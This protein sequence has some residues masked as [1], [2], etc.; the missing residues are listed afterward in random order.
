MRVATWNVNNVRKRLPQLLDWLSGTQPDVVALQELKTETAAFPRA[1]IEAAGYGCL[2]A[3]QTHLE[4]RGASVARLRAYRD[5]AYA[6]R[7][8]RRQA[9]PFHRGGHQRRRRRLPVPAQRQPLA[10]AQVR[11]QAGVVRAAHRRTR[12]LSWPAATRS[13][14]P[15]TSTSSRRT[16]STS[17]RPPAGAT[18][19]CCSLEARE[20]YAR[21]LA[22][23][24]TDA[25]RAN[26]PAERV[27]T[28]WDYLRNRWP[29]DAG[30]RIDH[31]LLSP[32]LKLVDA[33]VDREMRGNDEP[34]DHAP[35]WAEVALA[36][37]APRPAPRSCRGAGRAA[38]VPAGEV[39][40]QARLRDH[41]RAVR[42]RRAERHA[43]ARRRR[44]ARRALS[45]VIQKHWASRVCTTTS[46]WSSMA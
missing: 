25:L 27:Y 11:L 17:T 28:F 38:A 14:W 8:P 23:G 45:F 16:T 24:W 12:R 15:A 35:A 34:S 1:E 26:F 18:T 7:R 44:R 29:R 32:A 2:V 3:G 9:G 19:R 37:P 31:L 30:L 46:A 41:G 6:A 43:A 20:A 42:W 40:R 4:R 39:Q 5:P 22:Q 21:L 10:R 36:K 13:S 33:G